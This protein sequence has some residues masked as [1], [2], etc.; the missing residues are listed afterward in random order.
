MIVLDK[1]CLDYPILDVG[2]HSLQVTLRNKMN[3]MIGGQINNSNTYVAALNDISFSV[4]DGQ[5]VGIIGHNGSG[6]TTL[7]RVISKVYSPTS[8]KIKVEGNIHSLTD[9]T[10]G[11]DPDV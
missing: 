3:R 6:K 7:L 9:F 11:M 8:G 2:S 10:L 5:R 4:K 1:V